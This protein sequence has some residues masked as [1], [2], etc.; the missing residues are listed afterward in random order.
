M[1]ESNKFSNSF[2]LF[3]AQG[4]LIDWNQGFSE[5]F[6]DAAH[7]LRAGISAD[8]IRDG[9]LLSERALDLAHFTGLKLNFHYIN[10][11]RFVSV[12][13]ERTPAGNIV[14]QADSQQDVSTDTN[15]PDPATELLRSSALQMASSVLARRTQEEAELRNARAAADA[16]NQ[17][18]SHF[19]ATMSH[20]IRTPMNGILGMAQLLLMDDVSNEER[21]EFARIILGSGRS[22][23]TILNDILDLSKIEAGKLDLNPEPF[24]PSTLITEI[25]TLFWRIISS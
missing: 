24:D 8:D 21:K 13:L 6:T 9:C 17:A 22:L 1:D 2:A 18:K 12:T 16:A 19:L 23:L 25:A 20:E 15:Q 10:Q 4:L 11:R 5:E 14:R 7:L 3:D